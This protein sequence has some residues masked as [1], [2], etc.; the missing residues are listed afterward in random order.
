MTFIT[1][2]GEWVAPAP[3]MSYNDKCKNFFEGFPLIRRS[4][5]L[6]IV[7]P[8]SFSKSRSVLVPICS[9]YQVCQS[10]TW[11]CEQ[12]R[13]DYCHLLLLRFTT[14]QNH[15]INF[16]SSSYNPLKLFNHVID[17]CFPLTSL[18]IFKD[19]K[20]KDQNHNRDEGADCENDEG[21]G[22]V[23]DFHTTIVQLILETRFLD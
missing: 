9:Q 11:H 2:W 21:T 8:Q 5:N 17:P 14:S 18:V 4:K 6:N 10:P 16:Y 23:L 12:I 13:T 3:L 1:L 22:K 15:F 7:T 19:E 20:L